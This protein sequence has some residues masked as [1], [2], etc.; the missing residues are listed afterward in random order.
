MND[1]GSQ[2]MIAAVLIQDRQVGERTDQPLG[3]RAIPRLFLLDALQDLLLP[4]GVGPEPRLRET[5][6][7]CS[8][9]REQDDSNS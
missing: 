5:R 8:D 2:V 4:I 6:W 7:G 9:G 3:M 1:G